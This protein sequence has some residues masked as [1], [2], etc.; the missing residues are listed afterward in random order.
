ML[1]SLEPYNT[2]K[3]VMNVVKNVM[4]VDPFR[5]YGVFLNVNCYNKIY[6]TLYNKIVLVNISK[7]IS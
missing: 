2:V 6:G 1:T 7:C 3:N 4:N 5:I